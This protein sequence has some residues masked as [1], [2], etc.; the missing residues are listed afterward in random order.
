MVLLERLRA[1]WILRDCRAG[2]HCAP[3]MHLY[4]GAGWGYLADLA[5]WRRNLECLH[6]G[7]VELERID[8]CPRC[9]VDLATGEIVVLRSVANPFAV[10]PAFDV[11]SSAI[12]GW[13]PELSAPLL[14]PCTLPA[15]TP[16]AGD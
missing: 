5:T 11:D 4:T 6:G 13:L 1:W 3:A 2:H 16:T 12:E 10:P 7:Y 8:R 9:G 15:P 14:P